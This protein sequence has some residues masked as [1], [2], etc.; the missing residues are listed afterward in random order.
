[1]K[2]KKRIGLMLAVVLLATIM[3]ISVEAAA[4]SVDQEVFS[5]MQSGASVIEI[6]D[7]RL[8]MV[9]QDKMATTTHTKILSSFSEDGGFTWSTPTELNLPE[10]NNAMHRMPNLVKLANGRILLLLHRRVVD[11]GGVPAVCYSDD[12]GVTWSTPVRLREE[13]ETSTFLMNDRAI[14]L[15]SGRIVVPVARGID[16]DG[17]SAAEGTNSY[18]G[19]YYSDDNGMTWS[20]SNFI[21]H[22]TSDWRG[23]QEPATVELSNGNVMMVMRTGLGYL[24][25]AISTDGGA[26]WGTP[27]KMDLQSPCSPVNL[28]KTPDGRILIAWNNATPDSDGSLTPRTP[29]TCAI[30]SDNGETWSNFVN[31]EDASN[32][33][34]YPSIC[35]TGDNVVFTYFTTQDGYAQYSTKKTILSSSLVLDGVIPEPSEY[36][37]DENWEDMNGWNRSGETSEITDGG[38]LHL[39]NNLSELTRIYKGINIPDAYQF[40]TKVKIADYE[41]GG[42]TSFGSKIMDESYRLMLVLKSDGI[43]VF[44]NSDVLTKI[45]DITMDTDW[46]IYKAVVNAGQAD[47]YM[48]GELVGS[49]SLQSN[50]DDDLIEQWVNKS[51]DTV[52]VYVDYTK[53]TTSILNEQW[54]EISADWVSIGNGTEISPA[55]Q[56]HLFSNSDT[57]VSIASE[58]NVP[59]A[60]TLDIT[61]KI[62]DHAV[63]GANSFAVKVADGTKRLMLVVRNDGIYMI[64]DNGGSPIKKF[65]IVVDSE[66]HTY[67]AVVNNGQ[68]EIYLDGKYLFASAMQS[69]TENSKIELFTKSGSG[70]ASSAYIE[71]TVM[72]LGNVPHSFSLNTPT[73]KV[74][75]IVP[76]T[77]EFS[78]KS[79]EGADT[80]RLIVDENAEFDNPIYIINNISGTSYSLSNLEE[81]TTYYWK[82]VAVNSL[83]NTLNSENY[84]SFTTGAFIHPL[85]EQWDSLTGWTKT[86]NIIEI[87]PESQLHISSSSNGIV[88][89][90][91]TSDS[92]TVPSVYTLEMKVK[93]DDF[94]TT[95]GVSFGTKIVDGAYRLMFVLRDDGIYM[96]ERDA[97]AT[98]KQISIDMDSAW[99]TYK[100]AVDNG[101][102]EVYMD[103]VYL[104]T[105]TM[106]VFSGDDLT[107]HWVQSANSD[108]VEVHVDYTKILEGNPPKAFTLTSPANGA[109]VDGTTVILTWEN[110]VGSDR[111]QVIVADNPE[112]NNPICNI[113]N[114]NVP[115]YGVSGLTED[116]TY[117][118]KVLAKNS[119]G[120]TLA[121]NVPYTFVTS[122]G[123]G[124]NSE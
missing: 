72:K 5:G 50:T 78:W 42:A 110:A 25:K 65:D 74:T 28:R 79:A 80:Y 52:E 18:V 32:E 6:D 3:S 91:T 89:I 93:V 7:G 105:S 116:T 101:Q 82:V 16:A 102:A 9:G 31:I 108:A 119:V 83:G 98:T 115:S 66:W 86:G 39:V 15:S 45:G 118:W 44:D 27:V 67:R 73:D 124:N 13:D 88:K 103:D 94:T 57:T 26:T 29:L 70:D 85:D 37:V 62:E 59:T 41:S 58:I 14:Q 11:A 100:V 23:A 99:H 24:Y 46:H 122:N 33:Y 75:D 4:V 84:R 95:D 114:S 49:T 20:V 68:A 48:D 8:L 60:Y 81:Y 38:V 53:L 63:S 104:F 1:M 112:F 35:F 69:N 117:Y 22:S 19:S 55:G 2:V 113:E 77:T 47:I 107:E 92:V 56:L 21:T 120:E 10:I 61:A 109:N 87:S 71:S 40:E 111:F 54:N 51:G 64:D 36:I 43:Y 34:A 76:N 30:S 106:Q 97:T 121:S 123:A 90:N 12:G 96:T 17:S